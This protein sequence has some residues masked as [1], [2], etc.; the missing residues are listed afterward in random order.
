MSGK[1][2]TVRFHGAF[3]S[4]ERARRKENRVAGAYVEETKI[5]GKT[6]YLVLTRRGSR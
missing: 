4:K 1:G 2:K 5:K 6:R 3:R